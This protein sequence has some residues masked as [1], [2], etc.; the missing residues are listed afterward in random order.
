MVYGA[1]DSFQPFE[2]R[3]IDGGV[4]GFQIDLIRAVAEVQG[5]NLELRCGPWQV[6]KD[7]YLDGVISIVGMFD[8]PE[9]HQYADFSEPLIVQSSE[10]LV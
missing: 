3:N 5:W 6:I 7:D 4:K 8:Q 10:I 9:R 1:D 2:S